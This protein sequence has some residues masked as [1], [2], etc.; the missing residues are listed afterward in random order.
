MLPNRYFK[1]IA[2]A[3][4]V[5]L[6]M[7]LTAQS[8]APAPTMT[9]GEV[10]SIFSDAYTDIAGTNLNPN[11]GQATVVTE[12]DLGGNNTLLLSGLNYQGINIGSA[13]GGVAH[14]FS[15]MKYLHLDVMSSNS[16]AL[17]VFLNSTTSGEQA[18]AVPM[19]HDVW[20]SLNIP[21]TYFSDLGLTLN[22]IH[23]FKFDGDG[24]I[25]IDN[26]YFVAGSATLVAAPTPTVDAADVIS[27][28]SDAY[29]DIA[30]TNF[31]PNWGQATV[32]SEVDLSGNTAQLLT[33]LN[34]QGFNIGSTDGGVGHDFSDKKYLHL[35]IWTANSTAL[36]IFLISTTSGEKFDTVAIEHDVW[37]GL[38]IPLTHFSDQ[39][40]T[41]DDIHQFKFDGN[42]DIYID[43]IYFHGEGAITPTAINSFENAADIS[44]G[45]GNHW[46][47]Y[48]ESD[49]AVNN[50]L[51]PELV[52]AAGLPAEG[53]GAGQ[54]SYSVAS[55]QGWGG[56][57]AKNH[58]SDAYMDWT[59]YNY[60][61]FK[62]QNY[63]ASSM[64]S[65]MTMR[66]TLFV[67]SDDS[68]GPSDWGR[69][70]SEYWYS[71]IEDDFIFDSPTDSGWHEIRIPLKR[72][73]DAT[74][75]NMGPG[76]EYTNGFVHTGWVGK[77]G[78]DSLR[79]DR[80]VGY[81][82]ETLLA[83]ADFGTS[84]TG[85]IVTGAYWL[86][87]MKVE[88]SNIIPGCMDPTSTNY[89]P[90]A[91]VD[92]GSCLYAEDF[93]DITFKLNMEMET[94]SPEGV[95][96]AGGTSFGIPGDNP[97]LDDGTNGDE[98][99][100]DN[101]YTIIFSVLK[102]TSQDY[103]FINGSNTDWSEKEN[104][105]GQEC[106]IL[107]WSDRNI[108]VGVNDTTIFTCFGQCTSDG[109]CAIVD[110]VSVT[111]KVDM[112]D[113][114][115]D[116]AGVYMAGG[117]LGDAGLLMDDTD[118]DDIWELT[119]DDIVPDAD[120]LWK[121]RNGPSDGNW[122]GNWEDTGE[123]LEAQ[124]CGTV[125]DPNNGSY[126]DRILNTDIDLVLPAVCFGSC[127]P[128]A[129]AHDVDVTF[130]VDMSA[131]GGFNP[132]TDAPYVFGSFNNWDYVSGSVMTV[133]ADPN[134]WNTT[135]TL[136]S[137]DTIDYLFGYGSTFEAMTGLTCAVYNNDVELGVRQLVMPTDTATMFLVE[138]PIFG[139][140]DSSTVSVGDDMQL[141]KEFA[142]SAYPNPFNP[143]INLQYQ[144]P[145]YGDV[146][147][148]VVNMLGQNVRSLVDQ[149]HA[150]G[151]YNVMWNGQTAHG[152]QA[153]TGIYF[154]VVSRASGTSVTKVTLLK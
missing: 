139:T 114:E 56:F 71:F 104:I 27:V 109:S 72:A 146:K 52:D 87:D 50:Y 90:D 34:Y 132:S 30:G 126:G 153:G 120:F 37:L 60:F 41:L 106:A 36:K 128:C 81:G 28:Y 134:I 127:S 3:M 149:A 5:L 137:R 152:H 51:T 70:S 69:D 64:D 62:F 61:S 151:Y 102:N 9:A 19:Q 89:N 46:E 121:F 58:I 129:P 42:G 115:T 33:G 100:G 110:F 82:I 38:D 101:I 11:W 8:A 6:P 118:G 47:F 116:A 107:P 148:D 105:V 45:A 12:V 18:Y 54:Y 68:H 55:D 142:L 25:Y 98:T 29:T 84:E 22:D 88:Y 96:L 79:L 35:D 20:L 2:I 123:N 135:V 147:I 67:D 130:T 59:P 23:Q 138:T 15:T 117:G 124:G 21:L 77:W 108:E 57:V 16:T 131:E 140:C 80:V 85:D 43:N 136:Q 103:T 63:I 75:A 111:F 78:A 95:H 31:N 4:L 10:N 17:N 125:Y 13:D 49:D 14:D 24:D 143:D 48:F 122:G 112:M 83:S 97:M 93:V 74:G 113:V 40:L 66:L 154:I 133:T 76:S 7:L 26:I 99:A 144:I 141:P 91:T 86:D 65:T 94:V 32:Q 145:E 39:G 44:F 1:S 73:V 150:P 92:D 53:L 119:L